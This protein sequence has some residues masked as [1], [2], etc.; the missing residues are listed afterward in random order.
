MLNGATFEWDHYVPAVQLALNANVTARHKSPPFTLMFARKLNDFKDY[1]ND[2][3]MKPMSED[4]LMKRIDEMKNTVFHANHERTKTVTKQQESRFNKTHKMVEYK[5]G[6]FVMA[7]DHE[8]TGKFNPT[9]KGPYKIINKTK[10]S[11]ILQDYEGQTLPRNYPPE[12]LKLVRIM[13]DIPAD[14]I[15]ELENI[16]DHKVHKSNFLYRV[17]WVGYTEAEDTWEPPENFGDP[18]TITK[19]W[20][21]IRSDPQ[22]V[23]RQH[24]PN[25]SKRVAQD[26]KQGQ[27]KKSR[28]HMR[29]RSN[30]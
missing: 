10:T 20:K 28:Y 23:L 12:Q 8:A 9:Y 19:Y 1:R 22:Q 13:E 30:R 14:E 7:R 17:R 24:K 15:Y 4:M 16:V 26:P 3:E 25:P 27:P 5:I 11:Y 29:T 21:R 18:L 2:A 6:D